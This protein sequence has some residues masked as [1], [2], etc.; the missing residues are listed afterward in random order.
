VDDQENQPTSR[1]S[2]EIVQI[3]SNAQAYIRTLPPVE[4]RIAT[5]AAA[6]TPIWEIAQQT[7]ESEGAVSRTLDGI[8]AVVTGRQIEPYETG[9]LGADT[10]SGVTG[11]Y[12]DTGFG[13]LD[14][15]PIPD[16]TEPEE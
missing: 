1:G 10:D 14:T 6:G 7:R 5:L 15:K 9:G 3:L 2:E 12:G 16:N 13:A 11:G 4:R 8:I